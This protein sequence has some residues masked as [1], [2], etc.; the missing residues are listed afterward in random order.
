MA[1]LT[2][3]YEQYLQRLIN[4]YSRTIRDIYH[5]AI[6]DVVLFSATDRYRGVPFTLDTYP[7]VKAHIDAILRQMATRINSTMVNAIATAWELSNAKNDEI[8]N[9]IIAGRTMSTEVRD[10]VYNPNTEAL[11]AFVERKTAG[12]NLS[13]RVWNLAEPYRHELEA[14]LADGIGQGKSSATIARN[15]QRYLNEPERLYRRVRDERGVLQLSK[16]ARNYKPGQGIARS[17]YVNALR[18]ARTETNMAY[19]KSDSER[20]KKQDFVKG[21]KVST[22]NNHPEYDICDNLAGIYPKDFVFISWHPNCRCNATPLLISDD[23][24]SL[25]EDVLLGIT[26][27]KPDIEYVTDV[28]GKAKEWLRKNA[29]RINGW[30]NTPYFIKEN[31]KYLSELLK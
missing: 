29:E 3:K 11:R 18:L 17:S 9:E 13:D 4:T 20:W 31:K 25:Q 12:M 5:R 8:A 14:G 23:E 22:S 7:A 15:L 6:V 16:A 24:F 27:K 10:L 26:D 2:K 28:H 1:D 21:I 19:Q 30:Q